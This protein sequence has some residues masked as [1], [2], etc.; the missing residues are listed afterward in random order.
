MNPGNMLV[1]CLVDQQ[2]GFLSLNTLNELVLHNDGGFDK[3]LGATRKM[4]VHSRVC[5][6]E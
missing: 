5:A 6:M 3:S 2:D 4:A 1:A